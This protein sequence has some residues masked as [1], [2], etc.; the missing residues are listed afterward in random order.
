MSELA[1]KLLGMVFRDFVA[2]PKQNLQLCINLR[3]IYAVTPMK[4]VVS[5]SGHDC[6]ECLWNDSFIS[7]ST[8]Y[9]KI[10]KTRGK[11]SNSVVVLRVVASKG[12]EL[13]AVAIDA[14]VEN[15]P[16]TNEWNRK[17]TK[18]IQNNTVCFD[19]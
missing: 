19:V 10:C 3:I 9:M 1:P 15:K 12:T 2:P 16:Y 4:M 7:K 17:V 13:V 18:V 6:N 8:L 5:L 14:P 11:S